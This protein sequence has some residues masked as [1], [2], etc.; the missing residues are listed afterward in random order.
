MPDYCVRN[1]PREAAH[2][3]SLFNHS[4]RDADKAQ[5]GI[6]SQICCIDPRQA[7]VQIDVD[8]GHRD[9]ALGCG[10]AEHGAVVEFLLVRVGAR[11]VGGGAQRV[12]MR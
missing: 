5:S 2:A 7:R 6:G 10:M 8:R 4:R 11:R 9:Q 3:R 12:E 1:S